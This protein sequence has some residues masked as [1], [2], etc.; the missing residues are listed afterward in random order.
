MTMGTF[1]KIIHPIRVVVLYR[2]GLKNMNE[3]LYCL[4]SPPQSTDLSS[5]ERLRDGVERAIRHLIPQPS[6]LI[7]EET[8]IH[9][10]WCQ[11]SEMS[12]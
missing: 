10:A 6:N 5:I 11:I 7:L 3:S 1:N 4:D 2:I 8:A 12:C 9:Q